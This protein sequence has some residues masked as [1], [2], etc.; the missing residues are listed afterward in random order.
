MRDSS[1][2]YNCPFISL[3]YELAGHWTTDL[4]FPE[5][6]DLTTRPS[7][8]VGDVDT[9]LTVVARPA[10]CHDKSK[11]LPAPPRGPRRRWCGRRLSDVS[12]HPHRRVAQVVQT[13]H[14]NSQNILLT[15]SVGKQTRQDTVQRPGQEILT[16]SVG[17]QHLSVFPRKTGML[18]M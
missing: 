9:S 14:D 8:L 15:G 18:V 4:S 6:G 16:V 7:V 5:P 13:S 3:R 11:S 10:L 1:S 12:C 17:Y 2:D